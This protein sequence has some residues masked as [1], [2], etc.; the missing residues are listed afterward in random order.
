MISSWIRKKEIEE[1]RKEELEIA[2]VAFNTLK[3]GETFRQAVERVR[4]AR[5]SRR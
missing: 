2:E 4:S 5:V 3:E 1:A